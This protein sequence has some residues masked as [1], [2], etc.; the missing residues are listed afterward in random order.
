MEYRD[1]VIIVLSAIIVILALYFVIN[2]YSNDTP[3]GIE[4]KTLVELL[5]MANQQMEDRDKLAL[6]IQ[7]LKDID[8]EKLEIWQIA[9]F[10]KQFEKCLNDSNTGT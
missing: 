1:S 10:K 3:D 6:T 5:I 4:G 9:E 2:Y 8:F 7:I